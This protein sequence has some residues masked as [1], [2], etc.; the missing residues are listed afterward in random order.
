MSNRGSRSGIL[1]RKSQIGILNWKS[2]LEIS[3]G[4]LNWKSQL[5]ISTGNF[6]RKSHFG[7]CFGNLKSKTKI[8]NREIN[9]VIG[10]KISNRDLAA[11]FIRKSQFE[12]GLRG[13]KISNRDSTVASFQKSQ[14]ENPPA[15]HSPGGNSTPSSFTAVS[16]STKPLPM[17]PGIFSIR[18]Q[19]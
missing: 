7:I 16:T 8:S 14:M 12:I 2:Q 13:F 9:Q 6:N 4:N 15:N 17:S 19:K 11:A 1:F 18:P 10:S 3:T 5:E